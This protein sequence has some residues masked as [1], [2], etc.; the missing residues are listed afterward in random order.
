MVARTR[1][2]RA[3]SPSSKIVASTER[4]SKAT[5][6]HSSASQY[7]DARCQTTGGARYMANGTRAPD[8]DRVGAEWADVRCR[9]SSY[10]ELVALDRGSACVT[11]Y[12]TPRHSPL[13]LLNSRRTYGSLGTPHDCSTDARKRALALPRSSQ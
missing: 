9:R 4:D 10:P 6:G 5:S 11:R 8:S 2:T 13:R 7:E 3:E 12:G 1:R